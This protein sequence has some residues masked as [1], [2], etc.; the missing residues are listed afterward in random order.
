MFQQNH[1]PFSHKAARAAL[2]LK[3]WI[4]DMN[5]TTFPHNSTLK[6]NTPNTPLVISEILDDNQILS[7]VAL[8]WEDWFN[9]SV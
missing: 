8:P 5:A 9:E 2:L 4:T 6:Q 3:A 1:I 7:Y